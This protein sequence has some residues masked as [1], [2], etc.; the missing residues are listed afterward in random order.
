MRYTEIRL[1]RIAHEL[2][3]DLDRETVDFVPNYDETETTTR[4]TAGPLSEPAGEWLSGY[5]G[6]YGDQYSAT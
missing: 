2:L 1:D 3:N 6:R 5:C 4:G